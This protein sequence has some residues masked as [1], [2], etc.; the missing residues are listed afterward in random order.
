MADS[1]HIKRSENVA[2]KIIV[3]KK[4]EII[5][6]GTHLQLMQNKNLYYKLYNIQKERFI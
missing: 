5:E 4:G 3:I 6:M 2:D 1:K